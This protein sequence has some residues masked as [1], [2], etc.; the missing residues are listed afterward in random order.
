MVDWPVAPAVY[1]SYLVLAASMAVAPGPANLFALATGLEKGTRAGLIGV[2]GMNTGSL[3]WF[4][5]AAVGLG[6]LMSQFPGVFGILAI[7]GGLYLAWLGFKAP[8]GLFSM[9]LLY[10]FQIPKP[11]FSSRLFCRHLLILAALFCPSL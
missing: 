6:A 10:K 4:V 5:A 2:L 7:I 8:T 11:C 1:G 9:D 3:V